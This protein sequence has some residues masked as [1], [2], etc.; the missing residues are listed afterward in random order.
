M[1]RP[2]IDYATAK[3]AAQ[4][5]VS[6]ESEQLQGGDE[7]IICDS[8]SSEQ[9][10]GWIFEPVVEPYWSNGEISPYGGDWRVRVDRFTGAVRLARDTRTEHDFPNLILSTKYREESNVKRYN[11]KRF[12]RVR[13]R[14]V[15]LM[16]TLVCLIL[17]LKVRDARRQKM[18]VLR[19][20]EWA[21]VMYDGE[22]A[23]VPFAK[24]NFAPS[25]LVDFLGEEYFATVVH[26]DLGGGD[27]DDL[28]PLA[29]FTEL[30]S[31]RLDHLDHVADLSPIADLS[32]LRRLSL[33]GSCVVNISHLVGLTNLE[34]LDLGGTDVYDVKALA[35]M[36]KMKTLDLYWTRVSDIS[37]L[38]NM[39]KLKTLDLSHT[40][41]SDISPLVHMKCL[42]ELDLAY[43]PVS[44]ISPLVHMK[45]LEE[46]RLSCTKVSDVA[47]LARL[48]S[49]KHLHLYGTSVTNDDIDR[50]QKALPTC[51][52]YTDFP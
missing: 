44:D 3:E 22:T 1:K 14:T 31:A 29:T 10:W 23:T 37:P 46:L 9:P 16:V 48:T 26:V 28:T 43:T 25:W 42:E 18:A 41:V 12:F 30:E 24:P 38:A 52:I 11:V 32:R 8:Q 35:S 17:G 4:S 2:Q 45:C 40:R 20:E 5:L 7:Y 13:L 33:F 36:E 49:L 19:V 50:F 6:Q 39:K 15:I 47:P 21:F 51:E 27:Y 34:H